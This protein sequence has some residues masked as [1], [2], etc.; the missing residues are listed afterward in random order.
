M[1]SIFS[2]LKSSIK[3]GKMLLLVCLVALVSYFC[4]FPQLFYCQ[5]IGLSGFR[6]AGDDLFVSSEILESHHHLLRSIIHSAEMRVDSFYSGLRSKPKLI[7]CAT[8]AEYERY[9]SGVEGAG[10][11]LG[12]PWGESFIV[13]NMEGINVD[14]ISHELSHIELLKRLGWWETTFRV[15]QWFNEGIA[16][17]LDRRFV[18]IQDPV[19]RY[20][21]YSDEWL[22]YSGGQ[23]ILELDE[24]A[25][26]KTF[27]RGKPRQVM[28]AYMTSGME[29]S[30]WVAS[31]DSTGFSQFLHLM[32]SGLSF[33][34]AYGKVQDL[35][36]FK[37]RKILPMNPLRLRRSNSKGG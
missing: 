19:G 3:V 30:Y 20:L 18:D 14:V 7:I 10:C 5:T 22:S 1:K 2:R 33:A 16:L 11:S 27:F 35:N 31:M 26:L 13:V 15:P 28:L 8:P 4:L 24:I 34:E 25:S 32:E 36:Q 21:A 29:V 9:C 37:Y 6:F 12:T 17:M 23:M